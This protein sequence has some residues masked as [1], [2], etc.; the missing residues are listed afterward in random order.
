MAEAREAGREG[1]RAVGQQAEAGQQAALAA[2]F[3]Q[4]TLAVALAVAGPE[5]ALACLQEDSDPFDWDRQGLP[6]HPRAVAVAAVALASAVLRLADVCA[7][8]A[9]KMDSRWGVDPPRRAHRSILRAHRSS[10]DGSAQMYVLEAVVD[11]SHLL[12]VVADTLREVVLLLLLDLDRPKWSL[13]FPCATSKTLRIHQDQGRP[14][15]AF[16]TLQRR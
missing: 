13:Q 9:P 8:P 2:G 16:A 1:R 10:F 12:Q 3:L 14:P 5:G 7:M 6:A 11:S 15:T 4:V